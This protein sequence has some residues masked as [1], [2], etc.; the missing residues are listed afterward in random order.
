MK[1]ILF[2]DS[3]DKS[4][5]KLHFFNEEPN[6]NS[7]KEFDSENLKKIIHSRLTQPFFLNKKL[8]DFYGELDTV[9]PQKLYCYF[10]IDQTDEIIKIKIKS[11]I[12][13]NP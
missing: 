7:I 6:N 11:P 1:H 10:E 3:E 4:Y 9:L 2:K 13:I 8:S 12:I 5:S